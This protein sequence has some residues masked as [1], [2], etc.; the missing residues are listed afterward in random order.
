MNDHVPKVDSFAC[1]VTRLSPAFV[2]FL[3]KRGRAPSIEAKIHPCSGDCCKP[4][5]LTHCVDGVLV[6][7]VFVNKMITEGIG[8]EIYRGP[9]PH[10]MHTLSFDQSEDCSY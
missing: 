3:L 5:A 2:F 1:K 9:L 7:S 6:D 8:H 10:P 4:I